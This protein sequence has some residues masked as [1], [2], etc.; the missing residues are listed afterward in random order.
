MGNLKK[1]IKRYN[2]SDS[3]LVKLWSFQDSVRIKPYRVL[4][5]RL[6]KKKKKK[7]FGFL[8]RFLVYSKIAKTEI[9]HILPG[10]TCITSSF[11]NS[12]TREVHLLKSMT[13]HRHIIITKV[14]SL[15]QL[16]FNSWCHT[17]HENRQMYP[18]LQYHRIL[19]LP[20]TSSVPN[21]FISPPPSSIPGNQ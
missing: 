17:F 18:L 14:H 9:S 1:K 4:K 12:Y 15:Y 21:L 5:T 8:E 16:V 11:I 6:R 3:K 20:Y 2:Y 13:L 19:L 7:D 10:H